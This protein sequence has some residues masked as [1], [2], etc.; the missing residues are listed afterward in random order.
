MLSQQTE[1]H[2]CCPRKFSSGSKLAHEVLSQRLVVD[3]G[4]TFKWWLNV[5]ALFCEPKLK[6]SSFYL[7]ELIQAFF[8]PCRAHDL[9]LWTPFLSI[10]VCTGALCISLFD[11]TLNPIRV[12]P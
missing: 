5:H 1:F 7:G 9:M 6:I 10:I 8:L 3:L 12:L 4:Y 11:T 2:P